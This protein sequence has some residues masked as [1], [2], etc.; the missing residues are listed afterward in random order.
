MIRAISIVSYL[1]ITQAAFAD[2]VPCGPQQALTTTDQNTP[3]VTWDSPADA[4]SMLLHYV[5][6]NSMILRSG[7]AEIAI[8]WSQDLFGPAPFFPASVIPRHGETPFSPP[9]GVEQ[10]SLLSAP[11]DIEGIWVSS[12]EIKGSP[13]YIFNTEGLCL[14]YLPTLPETEISEI[15]A[16]FGPLAALAVPAGLNDTDLDTLQNA[17]GIGT[18]IIMGNAKQDTSRAASSGTL[19]L[20]SHTSMSALRPIFLSATPLTFE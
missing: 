9:L 2:P 1:T 12:L 5:G 19:L 14:G 8:G 16:F 15:A 10:I 20:T 18:L 4:G 3:I 6:A 13:A 17:E 7:W 11:Q